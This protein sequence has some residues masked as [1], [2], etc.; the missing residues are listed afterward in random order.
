MIYT[1]ESYRLQACMEHVSQD[2]GHCKE[3][4]E[5][6]NGAN[7]SMRCIYIVA[8]YTQLIPINLR[9]VRASSVHNNNLSVLD[10]DLGVAGGDLLVLVQTHPFLLEQATRRPAELEDIIPIRLQKVNELRMLYIKLEVICFYAY[11]GRLQSKL[12]S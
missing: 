11:R 9:A 12:L 5:R 2:R 4:K 8:I 10:L 3:K 7:E 1:T 6:T